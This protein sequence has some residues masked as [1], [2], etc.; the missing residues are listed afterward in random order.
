MQL[1]LGNAYKH[2][3][4][5]VAAAGGSQL[6]VK[7]RIGQAWSTFRQLARP[8]FLNKA[9]REPTRVFLLETLVFTKLLYGRCGGWSGLTCPDARKLSVCY[10]GLLRRTLGQMKT[11]E[12]EVLTD[13]AILQRIGCASLMVKLSQQRFLLAARIAR[14][15]PKFLQEELLL[16]EDDLECSWR[17]EIAVMDLSSWGTSVSALWEAWQAGKPGWQHVLR[18]AV[19]KHGYVTQLVKPLST[20]RG[21]EDETLQ[22]LWLKVQC[23]CHCGQGFPTLKALKVRQMVAHSWRTPVSGYVRGFACPV[24][25]RRYWTR[26]RLSLRLRYVSRKAKTNICAAWLQEFGVLEEGREDLPGDS[27]VSLAGARRVEAVSL[28][29]PKVFGAECDDAVALET[30]LLALKDELENSGVSF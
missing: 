4:T 15:A 5:T 17:S 6:E 25:L 14:F 16:E 23:R 20:D 9:L 13:Q 11:H 26:N 2:L 27:F 12:A 21:D 24:C 29:G 8:I 19:R 28:C 22:D 7:R 10:V 18:T 30:D 1:A 3:G